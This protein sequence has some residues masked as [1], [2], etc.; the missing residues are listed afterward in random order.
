[1]AAARSRRGASYLQLVSMLPSPRFDFALTIA[2]YNEW[3]AVLTR[4]E[5][6]PPG[7]S[8]DGVLGYYAIWYHWHIS[9]TCT[10]CGDRFCIDMAALKRLFC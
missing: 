8:V 5:H 7:V 2:L 4:P 6:I 3:Q 9:K 1:M 10:S